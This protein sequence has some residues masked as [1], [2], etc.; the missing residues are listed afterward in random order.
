MTRQEALSRASV[1]LDGCRQAV[2]YDLRRRRYL[3]YQCRSGQEWVILPRGECSRAAADH[4]EVEWQ[5]A[6]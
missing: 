2:G 3:A 1:N 6:C 5:P 4:P